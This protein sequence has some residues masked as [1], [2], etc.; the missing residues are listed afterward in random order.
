MALDPLIQVLETLETKESWKV[1]RQFRQLVLCWLEVVGP[2]VAAQTRPLGIQ[3][4]VLHV[5]TSSPV[6][7][8]NLVF[9][10]SRILE[11]LNPRL[12]TPITDI[13]F[14]S[15]KWHCDPEKRSPYTSISADQNHPSWVDPQSVASRL[16]PVPNSQD[17]KTAFQNW[18]KVVQARSQNLPLCPQC[19]CPTPKGELERWS[20]CALCA[21]KQW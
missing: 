11:K 4:Q 9:E 8:Q 2:V 18:A 19:R 17:P 16:A 5:A 6:W 1:R 14:S 15:A 21:I 12:S 13:R 10:R 7:A 20:V 3:R